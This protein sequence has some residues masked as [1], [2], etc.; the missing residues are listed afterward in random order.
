[1]LYDHCVYASVH[2]CVHVDMWL[3]CVCDDNGVDSVLG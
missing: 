2:V 1:M 3:L